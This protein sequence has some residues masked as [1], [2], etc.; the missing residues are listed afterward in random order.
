MHRTILLLLALLIPITTTANQASP[1]RPVS[2]YSIVAF[3]PATGQLGVAVQ[4]HWFSVG[5]MVPWARA[6]VGAVATQSLVEPS[7]GP[8]G[9]ELMAAGKTAQQALDALTHADEHPEIRQVGMVD[10]KGN[11]AT[12]TGSNCIPEAGHHAGKNYTVQANLM[13]N[14]TV[15]DA[16]AAAFEAAEGD[17][18]GRM[19]EALKAAQQ[20]G[21]DIR[22]KQSAAILVVSGEP[23]GRSWQDTLVDLRV[24]DNPEPLVELDRLLT[25]HRGYAKMNEGDLAIERDDLKGAEAAYGAAQEILG[26]KNLEATFW[27]AVALANAGEVDRAVEVFHQVFDKG[28]NWRELTPRLIQGGFLQV[29]EAT[30]SRIIGPDR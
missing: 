25:M 9:L 18:A 13:A 16:M 12:H 17:L 5:A 29:D 2:T 27:Y 22:G 30:L 4:S 11:V 28:E 24:E 10:A 19:L 1:I 23:T 26:E 6:G 3:D 8:L 14:N 20:A 7:Y 15:P 21:G